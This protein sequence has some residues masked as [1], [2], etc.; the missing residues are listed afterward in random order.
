MRQLAV[1]LFLFLSGAVQAL[2][3]YYIFGAA[4]DDCVVTVKSNHTKVEGEACLCIEINAQA[5]KPV[6]KLDWEAPSCE[7]QQTNQSALASINCD[8]GNCTQRACLIELYDTQHN[9]NYTVSQQT[10]IENELPMLR[11]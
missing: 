7:L 1:C 2:P 8:N 6:W 5:N 10:C 11:T 9:D 4:E 3:R